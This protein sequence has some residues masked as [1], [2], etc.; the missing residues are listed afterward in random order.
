M[1]HLAHGLIMK[2]NKIEFSRLWLEGVKISVIAD[3]LGIQS[4]VVSYHAN[5]FGLPSRLSRPPSWTKSEIETMRKMRRENATVAEIAKHLHRTQCAIHTAV[6]RHGAPKG[7]QPEPPRNAIYF[8]PREITF[9]PPPWSK[10][11]DIKLYRTAEASIIAGHGIY[12]AICQFARKY[13][14]MISA[15]QLR[16]H[17][18][19][20]RV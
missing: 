15:V 18:I 12:A 10:R 13:D 20:V 7:I 2:P 4:T 17:R 9:Y 16:W 1:A 19:A 6:Q 3:D 8:K 11:M 14:M 5:I